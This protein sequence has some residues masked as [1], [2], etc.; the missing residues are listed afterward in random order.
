MRSPCSTPPRL[1]IGRLPLLSPEQGKLGFAQA[2]LSN[3]KGSDNPHVAVGLFEHRQREWREQ[4]AFSEF[5]DMWWKWAVLGVLAFSLGHEVCFL[6]GFTGFTSQKAPA[7]S[8]VSEPAHDAPDAHEP[9]ESDSEKRWRHLDLVVAHCDQSL[10]WMDSFV[11]RP[12]SDVFI[13]NRCGGREEHVQKV[14]TQMALR[15]PSYHHTFAHWLAA[16]KRLPPG[17]QP[18]DLVLFISDNSP[19]LDR[20]TLD[21]MIEVA[22]GGPQFACGHR[23]ALARQ[24]FVHYVK[25]M[26]QTFNGTN[27]SERS[28]SESPTMGAW[29]RLMGIDTLLRDQTVLRVCFGGIF[30]TTYGQVL[31]LPAGL[32]DRLES[33]L[34]ADSGNRGH[35]NDFMERSWA[36]LLSAP[37]TPQQELQAL[38]G[39]QRVVNSSW[40]IGK[41]CNPDS[42]PPS[43]PRIRPTL[44]QCWAP[45]AELQKA[46]AVPSELKQV[47]AQRLRRAREAVRRTPRKTRTLVIYS[48]PF[49][50][51]F[52]LP[53]MAQ[54]M[55]NFR[56]FLKYGTCAFDDD[57]TT[58]LVV[59]PSINISELEQLHPSHG[60]NVTWLRRGP[61]CYDF[62]AYRVGLKHIGRKNLKQFDHFVLLN[63]SSRVDNL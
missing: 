22:A 54:Y 7:V 51:D 48:G 41:I 29:M 40:Y 18:Q 45:V 20:M 24:P 47:W 10:L 6:V 31:R 12:A 53:K 61:N 13:F 8:A 44:P 39:V 60:R 19:A 3:N 63:L 32:R 62:E 17:R 11:T 55:Q 1:D 26:L 57:V 38:H 21:E 15:S 2:R 33:C 30:L 43:L 46:L 25:K 4:R 9:P 28:S 5:R 27:Q 50:A 42:C 49:L 56:Y 16:L 36:A 37:M 23:R 52:K 59:G 35:E 14:P 34:S 58:L